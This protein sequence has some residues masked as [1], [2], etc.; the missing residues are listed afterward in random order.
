MVVHLK[1]DAQNHSRTNSRNTVAEVTG[2]KYPEQVRFLCIL[3]EPFYNNLMYW[4]PKSN[5]TYFLACCTTNVVIMVC[6]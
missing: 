1:M 6:V 4:F 5:V 3:Q 2:S